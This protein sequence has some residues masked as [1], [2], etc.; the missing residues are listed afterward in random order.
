MC[1]CIPASASRFVVQYINNPICE[2]DAVGPEGSPARA[3][4]EW[5]R[6]VYAS[7]E[8]SRSMNTMRREFEKSTDRLK[9][10]KKQS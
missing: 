2:P 7:D 1:V 8:A 5:V 10:Y 6:A 4:C 9:K 3:L